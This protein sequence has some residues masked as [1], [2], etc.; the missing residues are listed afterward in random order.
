PDDTARPWIALYNVDYM[1][2][3]P[4]TQEFSFSG[5]PEG[6]YSLRIVPFFSS[7]LEV[8]LHDI[9]VTANT[10][11]YVG[12]LNFTIQPFFKGCT[13]FECDSIAVQGILDENG[14]RD[15]PVNSVITRNPVNGRII[16]LNLSNRKISTISKDI[17]SLSQLRVLN[18]RNNSLTSLPEQIGYLQVLAEIFLDTNNLFEL[19]NE[20]GYLDSLKILSI[21]HN[22][23]YRIA[24]Q[25]HYLH[26]TKLDVSYNQLINFPDQSTTFPDLCNLNIDSNKI[27]TIPKAFLKREFQLLSVKYNR[28]CSLPKSLS[29]W[30]DSYDTN[31]ESTQQCTQNIY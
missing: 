20:L 29:D 12:T 2:Q 16:E 19:P 14:L 5:I 24:D 18:L 9:V 21:S 31:W 30:L 4:F 15:I 26:I 8:N 10:T 6:T 7:R 28:L 11:T 25:I 17:G 23:L 13:S 22:N 3:A 1:V 27:S